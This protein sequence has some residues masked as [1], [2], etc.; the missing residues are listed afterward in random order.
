MSIPKIEPYGYHVDFNLERRRVIGKI[1]GDIVTRVTARQRCVYRYIMSTD[2]T[3]SID[4]VLSRSGENSVFGMVDLSV[5]QASIADYTL[6][7]MKDVFDASDASQPIST[8]T[9]IGD[10]LVVSILRLDDGGQFIRI[11]VAKP[12]DVTVLYP[13]EEGFLDFSCL[14]S[15]ARRACEIFE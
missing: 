12:N 3:T 11:S 5:Q 14:L 8:T 15:D 13:L 6:D 7:L 4:I 9:E 10:G 1:E 2:I